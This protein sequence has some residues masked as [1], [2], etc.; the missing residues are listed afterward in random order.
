LWRQKQLQGI[1]RRNAG[2]NVA[3]IFAEVYR[4]NRWG[5]AQG[6]FNS[7]S[8]ST[9][10]HAELYARVIKQFISEHDVRHVV[11]LGCGDFRIGAQLIEGTDVVYTGVDVVA[12]L[13][14]SN[15]RHYGKER[16]RFER[17][18]IIDDELPPGD[19]CLIR[20]VLQHLSNQQISQVLRKIGQYAWVIVTEHYPAPGALS[21]KNLDKPCGE[22]VRI[23]DGSAVYLDALPFNYP[24]SGTL[25]DVDAGHWLMQPGER[26]R[27]FLIE[28]E[29]GQAASGTR[30]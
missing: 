8:G 5:G 21:S 22:D 23:Y 9:L 11:D 3:E 4:E 2:R 17:L 26:I 24:V 12:S 14:E 1:R 13:V 18:D 29:A 15:R 6:G 10:Q 25:L 20:Q 28:H 16:V 19:L 30:A 7:G 27:T